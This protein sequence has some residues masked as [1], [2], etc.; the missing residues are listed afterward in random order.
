M[1]LASQ[2][3]QKRPAIAA[4]RLTESRRSLQG[5]GDIQEVPRLE[6]AATHGTLDPGQDVLAA[7]D[8]RAG[9][10]RHERARLRGFLEAAGHDDPIGGRLERLG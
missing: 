2:I 5:L 10:L 9:M 3:A 6:A 4:E 1:D 7:P 8:P